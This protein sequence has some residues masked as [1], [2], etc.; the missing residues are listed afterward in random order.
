MSG[1]TIGGI[2]G[3]I[4]G[5]FVGA[6]QLGFMIG[7]MIGGFV[8]PDKVYGP[9]LTDA[10][11]QT[12][13]VGIPIPF[14]FGTFSIKGNII[15]SSKLREKKNKDRGKGGP[16]Q[17]TYQYLRDYAIGICE[18]PIK[19]IKTIKRNGKVVYEVSATANAEYSGDLSTILAQSAKWL[20][21]CTI[22]KGDELQMPDPTIEAVVGA[23]NVSPF[24]GLAYIVV[25]N[26]DVTDFRGAIPQYEFTV[27]MEGELGNEVVQTISTGI[28]SRFVDRQWP[29]LDELSDYTYEHYSY[30]H[31][32]GVPCDTLEE[33]LDL[34]REGARDPHYL[35]YSFTSPSSI[36]VG[37]GLDVGAT[38]ISNFVV[39]PSVVDNESLVLVYSDF[40]ADKFNNSPLGASWCPTTN[41]GSSAQNRQ[42]IIGQQ[43]AFDPGHPWDY[44]ESCAG[45]VYG[46]YPLFVRVRRKRIAPDSPPA[47]G[48]LIPDVPGFYV[49]PD[50]TIEPIREYHEQA[51]T[52]AVIAV[53]AS[54]DNQYTCYETGPILEAGDPNFNNEAYWT[55]AYNAAVSAGRVPAGWTYNV[56]YPTSVASA[57]VGEAE[58]V[59]TINRDRVL[60]SEVVAGLCARRDLDASQIYVAQLTDLLDGYAVA[61]VGGA[62]AFITPLSQAY[63]FDPGEWDAKLRFIKRGGAAVFALGPDDLVERDGPTIEQERVQEAELLRKVTV[64]YVD[65]AAGFAPAT[66]AA[67]RTVVTVEAKGESGIEIPVAMTSDDAARL[68]EK[69]LKVAWGEPDK[70]KLSLPYRFSYLTPTDV[71]FMTDKKGKVHRVRIME[72]QEDSGI[73]LEEL[74]KD[75]QS[76]YGSNAVG[77]AP[78][79][80]VL[81]AP[82]L[83]GPTTFAPINAPVMRD[84][85]DS[86]GLYLAARGALSGWAGCA[87]L[88]ST[89]GGATSTTVAEIADPAVIGYTMTPLAATVQDYPAEQTLDVYLPEAPVSVDYLQMLQFQNR[90]FLGDEVIQFQTVTDLGDNLYRLSGLIRSRYDTAP[91][92]H[93]T[94]AR[95]VLFDESVVFLQAQTWLLG[96]TV[97]FKAVSFGTSPDAYGW[98]PFTFSPGR[99]QTEWQPKAVRAQISGGD[100][101]VD[102]VGRRRLGSTRRSVHSQHF[103]GYRVT[104]ADGSG[105]IATHDVLTLNDTL[106]G[107][108]ALPGPITI[109]V[110]GLNAITGAGPSSEAITV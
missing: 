28:L 16:Q 22:Y 9:R 37:L 59:E 94:G 63:F 26:D 21:K 40:Q 8:D 3:G 7:S 23:G 99:S 36:F 41:D 90:A 55:A 66:Q 11:T 85:D 86:L 60:L 18:G 70:F 57:F 6:P 107:G 38:G 24:R 75:C 77:V 108:A 109:T 82:G 100:I 14:G 49:L 17:I 102:W 19:A 62:D 101:V 42:G 69:R 72:D 71:G 73:K 35:G 110:A 88:M 20:N 47:D 27:V 78:K 31:S 29:L 87:V 103:R 25:K 83:I 65:P 48:V 64:S 53:P 95:F 39:Q 106:V 44:M 52:F 32:S 84:Q 80:P 68:A 45:T 93:A 54:V 61:T 92:A 97:L 46:L 34:F 15:W 89:D 51:G 5:A 104:Y 67:E 33:A 56:D 12:S 4:I 76:A 43:F 2:A 98:Q 30:L 1:S 91:A 50:G 96:Q 10:Q 74:A 58:P 13:T 79:P 105:V 81:T